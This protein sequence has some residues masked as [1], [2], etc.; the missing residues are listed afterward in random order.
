MT[1][2]EKQLDNYLLD[3]VGSARTLSFGVEPLIAYLVLK[4]NEIRI[5]RIILSGKQNAI[6]NALIEERLRNTYV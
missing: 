6:P 1:L 3:F 2:G 5:A 4:E